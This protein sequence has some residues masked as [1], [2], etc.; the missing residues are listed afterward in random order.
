M[1]RAQFSCQFLMSGQWSSI[2]SVGSYVVNR[3]TPHTPYEFLV[4]PFRRGLSGESSALFEAWTL[5]ARPI[6]SPSDLRWYQVNT[7]SIDI[8]WKPLEQVQFRGVP[9]GYQVKP[10]LTTSVPVHANIVHIV[11]VKRSAFQMHFGIN[12]SC[13]LAALF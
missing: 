10:A 4:I 6:E 12:P 13:C 8:V 3:L 2:C 11:L 9:I 1:H 5:E 7:S